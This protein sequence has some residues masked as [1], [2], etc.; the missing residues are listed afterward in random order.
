MGGLGGGGMPDLSRMDPKELERMAQ[1]MG[2][3]LPKGG[4][5]KKR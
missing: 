2:V 3:K 1:Q 5:G 4:M